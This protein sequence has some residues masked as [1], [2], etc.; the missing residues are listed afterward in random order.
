MITLVS[1]RC[2][3]YL[4]SITCS[5]ND[6]EMYCLCMCVA[7]LFLPDH[8]FHQHSDNSISETQTNLGRHISFFLICRRLPVHVIS[9]ADISFQL[10]IVHLSFLM[11]NR[12]T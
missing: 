6:T 12:L 5:E 10:N 2:F 4:L 11:I 7:S 3:P 9:S 8:V 1:L